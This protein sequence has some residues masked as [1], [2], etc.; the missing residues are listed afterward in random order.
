MRSS[1]ICCLFIRGDLQISSGWEIP[2]NILVASVIPIADIA[3]S[4]IV[5]HQ[6]TGR[7]IM[8]RTTTTTAALMKVM[9]EHSVVSPKTSAPRVSRNKFQI[10]EYNTLFTD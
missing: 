6:A 1:R 5:Y 2:L 10:L 4:V 7:E 3:N 8:T 9:H